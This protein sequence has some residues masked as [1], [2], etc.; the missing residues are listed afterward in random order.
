PKL[1]TGKTLANRCPIVEPIKIEGGEIAAPGKS[2]VASVDVSDPDGDALKLA[3][4]LHRD[5]EKLGVGGDREDATQQFP[6][7]IKS[8]DDRRVQVQLPQRPGIYRLYV[9][10]RDGHGNG[11][12]ANLPILTRVDAASTQPNTAGKP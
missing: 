10:A 2:V 6:D 7:A 5:A 3:W 8:I 1:W 12:T 11:A 9:Y 4:E